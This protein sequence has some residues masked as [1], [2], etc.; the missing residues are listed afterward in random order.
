MLDTTPPLVTT[1]GPVRASLA[2]VPEPGSLAL[3][4]LGLMGLVWRKRCRT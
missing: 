4:G 2:L 3:L 1:R